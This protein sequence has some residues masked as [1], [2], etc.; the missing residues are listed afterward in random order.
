MVLYFTGTG[1]S[2]YIAKKLAERLDDQ[3]TDISEYTK[4]GNGGE[5][6][7]S[8]PFVFVVPTYAYYIPLVVEDFIRK[9]NFSGNTD[10]YFLLTCGA[11]FAQGGTVRRLSPLMKVKGLNNKGVA[12]FVMPENYIAMFTSP[13]ETKAA[14]I[15][16]SATKGIPEIAEK[17]KN[18]E[19]LYTKKRFSFL[20]GPINT[21]FYKFYVKDKPYFATD[22]CISC[23]KCA[24]VCPLANITL[25]NG[26][27]VWHGNCTQCMAC[28]ARCPKQAI[29]YG[30]KLQGKRRYFL[31]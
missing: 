24:N 1:N 4:V 23:G 28:I 12:P 17:I 15:I 14:S 30:K 10:V 22:D 3:L 13:D 18:G 2:R 31:D 5:F 26:K 8:T 6:T 25:E 29:E 21:L 11:F 20:A 16:E 9:S 19:C 7:S 27:P